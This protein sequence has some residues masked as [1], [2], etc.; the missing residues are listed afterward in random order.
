MQ[1]IGRG[2]GRK[3]EGGHKA[4]IDGKGVGTPLGTWH[5]DVDSADLVW[6]LRWLWVTKDFTS[7]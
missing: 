6:L 4:D 1:D 3:V 2:V 7:K 5:L